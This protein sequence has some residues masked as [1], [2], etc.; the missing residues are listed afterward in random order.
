M[1]RTLA[2]GSSV[3]HLTPKGSTTPY[4]TARATPARDTGNHNER[5]QLGS[6][7]SHVSRESTSRETESREIFRLAKK[8]LGMVHIS[9]CMPTVV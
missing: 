8:T 3:P 1:T 5:P 9:M 6:R 4:P 7:T 2:A